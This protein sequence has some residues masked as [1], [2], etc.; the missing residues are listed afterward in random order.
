VQYFSDEQ[1]DDMFRLLDFDQL[2]QLGYK[3]D[4]YSPDE[5]EDFMITIEE[6]FSEL[7]REDKI[8]ELQQIGAFDDDYLVDEVK[9]GAEPYNLYSHPSLGHVTSDLMWENLGGTLKPVGINPE[10][11]IETPTPP[12][13]GGTESGGESQQQEQEH[14]EHRPQ[15][16][17]E[18]NNPFAAEETVCQDDHLDGIDFLEW[19]EYAEGPN[20]YITGLPN[21][22]GDIEG[23]DNICQPCAAKWIYDE[24][25]PEGEGY[26][27]VS[28]MKAETKRERLKREREEREMD[29]AATDVDYMR[30]H[31]AED[32]NIYYGS[33][34]GERMS[35]GTIKYQCD[36]ESPQDLTGDQM[37]ELEDYVE[38]E[39]RSTG[40]GEGKLN[41]EYTFNDGDPSYDEQFDVDVSVTWYHEYSD[42]NT[43]ETG[44]HAAES[45]ELPFGSGL[46]DQYAAYLEERCGNH[47]RDFLEE[48]YDNMDAEDIP[49]WNDGIVEWETSGPMSPTGSGY[50]SASAPPL[51]VLVGA[52][53]TFL[54][55]TEAQ[56]DMVESS[57]GLYGAEDEDMVIKNWYG[58]KA[59]DPQRAHTFT[60]YI[61]VDGEHEDTGQITVYADNRME[62][63][64]GAYIVLG[65]GAQPDEEFDVLY[66][67]EDST[68]VMDPMEF[69]EM[70]NWKPMD[71]TPGLKRQ[72]AESDAFIYAYNEGHSDAR[73]DAGYNV[74]RTDRELTQFKKI[75]KQAEEFAADSPFNTLLEI[76]ED[77][78][79]D[80]EQDFDRLLSLYMSL[81]SDIA[82]MYQTMDNPKH[83]L[84]QEM[85]RYRN[86]IA[87]RLDELQ[88]QVEIQEEIQMDAE[89]RRLADPTVPIQLEKPFRTGYK[90][91]FGAIAAAFTIPLALLGLGAVY[92]REQQ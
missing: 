66:Q 11:E 76:R 85:I 62:A 79:I 10:Y 14:Q 57:G 51:G 89:Q 84:L 5:L 7:D 68:P 70:A 74:R 27:R 33:F 17:P 18:S 46:V 21:P 77:I 37:G 65:E 24:G 9:M 60:Y 49:V 80:D 25:G 43:A 4:I 19:T 52:G 53:D 8:A 41:F 64:K 56:Q 48:Y 15:S 71:G 45:H 26:Y 40:D 91:G 20:C 22:G 82:T 39:I 28:A 92:N 38:Q 81:E 31:Y 32:G 29:D 69:G 12:S 86:Q 75:F 58:D 67:S 88:E 72:R 1:L 36:Y 16:T 90:L 87:T 59:Y 44:T 35:F 30:Q 73:R 2:E 61:Y 23:H 34:E 3:M 78:I 42:F 6:E 83:P 54:N 13:N 50:S 63:Y 55:Y 47:W